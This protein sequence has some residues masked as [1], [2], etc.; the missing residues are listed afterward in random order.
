ML[1][2]AIGSISIM[3][4]RYIL[5]KLKQD[6]TIFESEL[7]LSLEETEDSMSPSYEAIQKALENQQDEDTENKKIY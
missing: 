3:I 7:F 6:L 4:V 2:I 1:S 5:K